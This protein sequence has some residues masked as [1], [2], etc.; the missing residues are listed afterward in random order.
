MRACA[1]DTE[2]GGPNTRGFPVEARFIEL[3]LT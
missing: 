2:L 3:R 1:R